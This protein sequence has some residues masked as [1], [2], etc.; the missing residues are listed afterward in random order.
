MVLVNIT[1]SFGGW[2]GFFFCFFFEEKGNS[3]S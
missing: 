1:S 2:F 3:N